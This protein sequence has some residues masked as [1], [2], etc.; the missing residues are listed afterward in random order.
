MKENTIKTPYTCTLSQTFD[1]SHLV[2]IAAPE[3]DASS[4]TLEDQLVETHE[5]I[6]RTMAQH[7][8]G[9][10]VLQLTIFLK[11]YE[12]R[13]ACQ[14]WFRSAYGAR[15]PVCVYIPQPPCDGQHLVIEATIEFP[16][17]GG[18]CSL[19]F[20][21]DRF[22]VSHHSGASWYYA[23]CQEPSNY[24]RSV[25]SQSVEMFQS[26]DRL[27]SA[28][29]VLFENVIRTWL[30]LGNITEPCFSEIEGET[31][32]YKELNRGR[33][34]FFR[35]IH[36]FD[37]MLPVPLPHDVYPAST[38][39]GGVGD[40]MVMS[41]LAVR[42]DSPQDGCIVPLE[43]PQQ[44]S[45]FDYGEEYS[46]KSPKFA[47][48][49]LAATGESGVIFV[50]GTAS[51]TDSES[52]FDGDPIAQTELTLENIRILIDESN[53]AAHGKPGFG[54][55]LDEMAM[56]RVY[57]KR[58]EDY[59]AIRSVCERMIPNVPKLYTV[60]DVCRPELLVE[61]EGIAYAGP[62]KNVCRF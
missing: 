60:A 28:R 59:D 6:S 44:V 17:E 54:V 30:Y 41:A 53:L 29:G 62:D 57:V 24:E 45:A 46:L 20:V 42:F 31:Q 3:G 58:L 10:H 15:L 16:R 25:Y 34:D 23:A 26:L 1:V 19:E 38:G 56:A 12:E 47:R 22:L 43:N 39:I 21:N 11:N 51:I 2:M 37:G 14:K 8:P 40:T 27:F 5:N 49:L 61:I 55:A 32:R 13:S 4:A 36:F 35:D 52:R 9:G 18:A 7:A 50:S 33:T 48:A